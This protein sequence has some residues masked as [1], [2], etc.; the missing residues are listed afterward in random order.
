[1][2]DENRPLLLELC[3]IAHKRNQIELRRSRALSKISYYRE[4]KKRVEIHGVSSPLLRTLKRRH[5][6]YNIHAQANG[7]VLY[8]FALNEVIN[9]LEAETKRLNRV[10]AYTDKPPKKWQNN[11]RELRT[12]IMRHEL[13]YLKAKY[14]A[15][16]LTQAT[17]KKVLSIIKKIDVHLGYK[18][19]AIEAIYFNGYFNVDNETVPEP[20]FRS[21]IHKLSEEFEANKAIEKMLRSKT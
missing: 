20:I 12:V 7:A 13:E 10:A 16:K 9:E 1:M 17:S 3:N 18:N 4:I 2:E 11:I 15:A 21:K 19:G 6:Y 14:D 5:A 8:H